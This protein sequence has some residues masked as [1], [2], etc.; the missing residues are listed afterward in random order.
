MK[1]ALITLSLL[2]I[3]YPAVA[4]YDHTGVT[5][6]ILGDAKVRINNKRTIQGDNKT[7][8]SKDANTIKVT[9]SNGE[10]IREFSAAELAGLSL[11]VIA[12]NKYNKKYE[13]LTN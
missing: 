1:K 3:T 7:F 13:I 11:I 12:Q 4:M 9:G 2:A 5:V 8:D 10:V 6:T